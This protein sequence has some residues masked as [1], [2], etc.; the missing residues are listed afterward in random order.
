V[1]ENKGGGS[2]TRDDSRT[3]LRVCAVQSGWIAACIRVHAASDG[4][5]DKVHAVSNRGTEKRCSPCSFEW[6]D[7]E[8]MQSMQLR[9]EEQ[10]NDAVPVE[11]SRLLNKY[12][13]ATGR[14]GTGRR[15]ASQESHGAP[16]MGGGTG[17]V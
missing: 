9:M 14:C 15:H 5:T 1:V 4:G 17:Y 10:R 8:K 7:G 12:I 13:Q 16:S 11:G 6:R 2:K 3:M